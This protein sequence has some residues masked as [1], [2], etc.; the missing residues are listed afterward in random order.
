MVT[1]LD[2]FSENDQ[3]KKWHQ[4]LTDKKRQLILGLSTSTKALAIASSLEKEDRIV[5]LMST[6]GEA[7]GLVSDLISILGEELVY[8]FLVDD[9]PMVEF[10]MSSQEKIISRVEALRFLTDSSKKGIL[11][12]NIAASRLILPSPNAF[13]DS[14]VKI[15]VGEEYDQHAFIHQLKENGYR[16]VTQ[17]QT[18]G[19]FSLRGDILD[20][21]EISQLEPC[22]IEFFGD[23]IDGIRSFEVETQLSKENKTELTIFPASDM[24]LREKD[25]QRGQSALEKQISKTLSPIL[26][27]YLEEILS[28]FHQKQSHADSRKFLSLCYD[29]TWT[30]FDYIEKDTPIF[31]DDY[32]KLMNQYEVFERELAQYFTE[33]LQNSKAFSDMQYFSDIEQIYKKQSPVTFFS[34]LQKGLGNLKFDKIYQFNQYPMQEF[35]NQFSFLKEE[36][37]R[38]KKMDYTIILQSSNSMGSKTLEDMLEEYQIKLDSRDKTNICKESVNLIEGN[39]RHG[40]HFVDEKI[41]LITEHE[42]FQKKLKRRFRR[43]HVSNAERLKDYNELEKGDYVVHHIHGIGQYLGIETIEIKGIHRD[44]V[45]VQ[46]Q[47]GDQ[48]SIPVEQIHLLSKYISSDGKA[49][50]L[51]KLNDGHF[52]KAKQKVKN[53]VEDIADD[54]I[55]LYSERSQLKGFAF[56]A[57]DDDQDAFDDAFPYVETDDQLRSIEEIKRDMQ[58]SQPMDRLLVGDVGFGKTEVAMRA[59]FK[60][61]N[62]HKQVV[63]L[64]PT[65]VLAQ[66]HYTNFKERFQNFAVNIDVLSRFRSKKEQTATLEKL[67]NGQV[68]ILIG[69]HRVLSKDVVFADLGLMI[70]DEEQRFGVKH[71]E[72]LKE[73]KKQVDVLTLT[74]TPIPRTLHMSMLGIRDLS[75]IET[76]PT[77][78]YPVQT[79]VLEKNDSVI[80]DAVLR[81]M[82][83]GGQV[84]YLYNKVD[85]IVQKVSELQ[86]L[87]PEASIGYVHG[88]MSEVQLENT[89]LD[90]IEGQYDILVTTTIIETGVDIPNANTLFIENA[91]HMGLSTLYQL[92]GRVGRS[93]RIA[94]AYL[95]YRPEKSISEVS[96]KRLEAIKGFTELGSGFKIAMRDLSI[97]GAGNLLGKSQSGFIDSV[98][99]ELYSQ[100]LEEAIAKRNGNANANTRTKGNAELILQIDAY[101][102]DTYI[103]DQRHKIE[104]YK[105]IRQIDNRVNYEELQEELIDRFGEYPDVVAYLLEIGLVKSY[106]DKVFVQ[107]VERKDNKITIQFEKVTQ[108][109]FLAQDY[110]K[111]LSVTNLKAGIAENKGLMELVFDVQNKKDYEILEGLLIFGESLLEIKESKEENSI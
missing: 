73:L 34:N 5:L 107:R 53:Q 97:R 51:N 92:R 91:D 35:F 75:V 62:D 89:L 65:T 9:A 39:L 86:E 96:E 59:A 104:I 102:P 69:T 6:Y 63:I 108:R 68:D 101:L 30:V 22:R 109:L 38:Y 99:F 14:I 23:E 2:L 87:I 84:Y 54:L 37:E 95:M 28:S 17:V 98:G 77:N 16:K 25:Y 31:F 57:D 76:P 93:N 105:K 64:V 3:I 33:E 7:E 71:K 103:S 52:K 45:S 11:V 50:K 110:F 46:Y 41:L 94:Y 49:P 58:A 79:Y 70:I 43:Q 80:R 55:K 36:I 40:F 48:I 32:Q 90:F 81:E 8:P 74:A 29:K 44:Y 13:K 82:E 18:Q 24:L 12:C 21:F 66:Q 10:L 85:T 56:S 83:R 67:K 78:R 15:S 20:I 61:V 1:L 88:R 42:I 111:A 4:N 47:N 100:L 106:L 27:S 72:T 60:A 26:K 19:E